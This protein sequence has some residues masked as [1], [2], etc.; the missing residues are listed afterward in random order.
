MSPFG[1]KTDSIFMP[2]HRQGGSSSEIGYFKAAHAKIG[3][4]ELT[5]GF[6]EVYMNVFLKLV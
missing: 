2:K 5:R 6:L 1:Y 3:S 4:N